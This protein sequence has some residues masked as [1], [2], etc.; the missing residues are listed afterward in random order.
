V[1]VLPEDNVTIAAGV[2]KQGPAQE[3]L[4][5]RFAKANGGKSWYP[6][7][8]LMDSVKAEV[9]AL[10]RP[11]YFTDEARLEVV[12][13]AATKR[14]KAVLEASTSTGG[15]SHAVLAFAVKAVFD[16][17]GAGKVKSLLL[18]KLKEELAGQTAPPVKS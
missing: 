18:E 3:E 16:L 5:A 2:T 17:G 1:F 9:P 15:A 10:N 4:R 6:V 11:D 7:I 13:E 12:A 14:L 8:P